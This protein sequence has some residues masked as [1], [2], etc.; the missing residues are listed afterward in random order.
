MHMECIEKFESIYRKSPEDVAFCP[1]RVCPV[2]AH[3]D[4]QLGKITGFAIDK[5]IHIAY[6]PK[7]NGVVELASLQ[8]DKRAQWHVRDVPE[9]KCN[10]W[11]DYLRGA[12]LELNNRYTLRTGM[13]GVIQGS[14]PIG[15]LSSSAAL[16]LALICGLQEL[17]GSG[18]GPLGT[19]AERAVFRHSRPHPAANRSRRARERHALQKIT[20]VHLSPYDQGRTECIHA[21][22]RVRGENAFREAK[23]V[24]AAVNLVA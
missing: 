17:F 22:E 8:F 3:S 18:S 1:Y 19:P 7:A 20:S 9:V 6:G 11:A 14:L 5:G 10:D 16:E 21:H 23:H 12:T 15:G 24:V 13:S 4:H 2:G